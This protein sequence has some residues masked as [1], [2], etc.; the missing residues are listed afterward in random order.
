MRGGKATV[1]LHGQ[2]PAWGSDKHY[3]A[4]SSRQVALRGRYSCLFTGG[5]LDVHRG[6]MHCPS[7]GGQSNISDSVGEDTGCLRTSLRG[8]FPPQCDQRIGKLT[9]NWVS[10]K[11]ER[12]YPFLTPQNIS[13]QVTVVQG[14]KDWYPALSRHRC[15]SDIFLTWLSVSSSVR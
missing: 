3:S 4:E 5:N 1:I 12:M 2:H 6:G 7:V 11:A 15:E 14:Q 10:L 13:Q 8:I 9:S